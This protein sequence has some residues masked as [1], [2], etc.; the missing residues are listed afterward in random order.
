MIVLYGVQ[1]GVQIKHII[2]Q[3]LGLNNARPLD[4]RTRMQLRKSGAVRDH[5]LLQQ[6]VLTHCY[7]DLLHSC[8]S[9]AVIKISQESCCKWSLKLILQNLMMRFKQ[10]L[11]TSVRWV[12]WDSCRRHS[13]F[14]L[15]RYRLHLFP[16]IFQASIQ[17]PTVPCSRR[18]T[19]GKVSNM[20]K[21]IVFNTNT[22]VHS[23]YFTT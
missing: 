19:L 7:K 14:P 18:C 15:Q 9:C 3:T 2:N 21:G 5:F 6:V 13:N 23:V 4:L 8:I 16:V 20:F 11:N 12:A 1:H 17:R 22:F 10:P